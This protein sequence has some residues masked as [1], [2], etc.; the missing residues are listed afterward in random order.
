V[1]GFDADIK[2][3]FRERDRNA[4]KGAFDL[5][6]YDDVVKHVQAILHE[7][8]VGGMPCDGKWSPDQVAILKGWVD[9]GTPR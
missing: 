3:L 9:A 8:T 1:A 6:D 2:P 7:V 4:M 5:W